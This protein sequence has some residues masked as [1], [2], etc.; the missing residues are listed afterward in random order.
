MSLLACLG[1]A[2]SSIAYDWVAPSPKVVEIVGHNIDDGIKAGD[3]DA[4]AF[5]KLLAAGYYNAHNGSVKGFE[6]FVGCVGAKLGGMDALHA[7]RFADGLEAMQN[8]GAFQTYKDSLPPEA[9]ETGARIG[10]L[11]AI[12]IHCDQWVNGQLE[13][14]T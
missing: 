7:V 13:A 12:S 9:W 3:R 1:I 11:H 4:V 14:K 2:K 5:T 6:Q 8:S 10:E